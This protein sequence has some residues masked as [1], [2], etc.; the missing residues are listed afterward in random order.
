MVDAALRYELL[1]TPEVEGVRRAGELF[2][3]I[4]A[5]RDDFE[6]SRAAFRSLEPQSAEYA[7]LRRAYQ[8][9]RNTAD[10]K[11][12]G[13]LAFRVAQIRLNLERMRK[14]PIDRNRTYVLVNSASGEGWLVRNGDRV[15]V[16]RTERGDSKE[17][18][19]VFSSNIDRLIVE[20][21]GAVR[22]HI[23][24]QNKLEICGTL[25]E[26][27]RCPRLLRQ[28]LSVDKPEKLANRLLELVGRG[29]I[30][31]GDLAGSGRPQRVAINPGIPIHV[32]YFTATT[33]TRGEVVFHEDVDLRDDEL[34]ASLVQGPPAPD[35]L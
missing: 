31:I 35:A 12:L 21:T 6:G 9:T 22:F 15:L 13:G 23:A 34:W 16:F 18:L 25:G 4:A 28:T 3:N 11:V 2:R 32:A 27:T 33:D 1:M 7:K 17:P 10:P 30:R 8:E 26:S 19:P 5:V 20:P 14:T 29:H 24:G